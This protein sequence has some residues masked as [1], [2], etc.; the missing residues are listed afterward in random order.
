MA[1][2]TL[3]KLLRFCEEIKRDKLDK[4]AEAGIFVGYNTISKAYRVSQKHTSRVIVSQDVHFAGNEQWNW[5]GL[6]KLVVIAYGLAS[7]T[8]ILGKGIV[9]CQ[10]PADPTVA[11]GYLSL[12]FLL[13]SLI[14]G[15]FSLIYPYQRKS[16]PR[17]AF[18]K[19]TSFSIFFN[20]ALFTTGLAITLL[21]W[22]TVTNQIYLTRNVHHNLETAC[23]TAMTGLLGGSA[24]LYLDSSLFWLVALMFAE[25]AQEDYFD[26]IE[27]NGDSA[28]VL[29]L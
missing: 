27:E 28:E 8:P 23:P 16:V 10:Y 4:K 2:S 24:F 29:A 13:A 19:S 22:P 25:N 26:E 14:A 9:I 12:A 17:G 6:T 3:Q 11:L 5:E 18:F 7:G 1:R 20:I 15:Y 21:V